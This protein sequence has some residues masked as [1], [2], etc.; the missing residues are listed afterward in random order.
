MEPRGQLQ[1]EGDPTHTLVFS[2]EGISPLVL[3]LV[4]QQLD[5]WILLKVLW[6]S[7]LR[8]SNGLIRSAGHSKRLSCME[9]PD[10]RHP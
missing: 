10:C 1:P 9:R 6:S 3:R 4:L 5:V 7:P 8:A 2:Q